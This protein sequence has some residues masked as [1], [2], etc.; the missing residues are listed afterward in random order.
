MRQPKA[1]IK[2]LLRAQLRLRVMAGVVVI[3]LAALAAFDIAAVTTMRRYLLGQTDS[4]LPV[5]LTLTVPRLPAIPGP[6]GVP[7]GA[8]RGRSAGPPAAAP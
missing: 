5:A 7:P 3:T 6:A 4:N 8:R 2:R 1:L